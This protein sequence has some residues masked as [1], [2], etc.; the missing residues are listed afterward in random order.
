MSPSKWDSFKVDT[1]KVVEAKSNRFNKQKTSE[2]FSTQISKCPDRLWHKGKLAY[3]SYQISVQSDV[4]LLLCPHIFIMPRRIIQQLQRVTNVAAQIVTNTSQFDH[5]N[6]PQLHWL[7]V[8]ETNNLK[9]K[10]VNR[11]CSSWFQNINL[12]DH[13][14]LWTKFCSPF[15]NLILKLIGIVHYPAALYDSVNLNNKN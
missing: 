1:V 7:L 5:I 8:G 2:L 15:Q 4:E 12:P 14:G 10:P 6:L 3:Y 11:P 9:H 13:C